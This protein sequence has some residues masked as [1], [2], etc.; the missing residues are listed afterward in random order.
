[1]S[2]KV[3][4][5][6]DESKVFEELRDIEIEIFKLED[7]LERLYSQRRECVN[8]LGLNKCGGCDKTRHD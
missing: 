3:R 2:M 8:Y 4:V 5:E 6:R 7:K 1:M